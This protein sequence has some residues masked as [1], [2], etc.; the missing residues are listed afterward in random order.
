MR[1]YTYICVAILLVVMGVGGV[2]AQ[3]GQFFETLY[4]VPVME[5]I[6]EIPEMALSF[7]KVGGRIAEAGAIMSDLS[8]REVISFYNTSLAQMGWQRKQSS[9]APYIFTREGEKLSIFIDKSK[10]SPVIRFLLQPVSAVK[11]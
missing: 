5:G 1:I 11:R 7:D 4:D 9:Y 3:D 10:A 8:D 2:Q 6:E